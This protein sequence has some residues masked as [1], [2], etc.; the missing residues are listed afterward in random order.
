VESAAADVFRL[1]RVGRTFQTVLDWGL[2][3]TFDRDERPRY[4]AS[5]A[6]A[7]E[8]GGILYVLSFSDEGPVTGPHPVSRDELTAAFD[9][10]SGWS[11]AAMEPERIET[12]FHDAGASAWLAAVTKIASRF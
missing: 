2:F 12:R 3:H 6:A 4:A 10:G 9:G 1:E 11:V 7:T 5:I 8:P